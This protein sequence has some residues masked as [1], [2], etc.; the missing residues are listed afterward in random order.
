VLAELGCVEAHVDGEAAIEHLRAARDAIED[1]VPRAQIALL[2]GR[3]LFF[4]RDEEADAV[5]TAALEELAGGVAELLDAGRRF[6][7]VGSRNPA[8]I[9]WQSPA[10]LALLVLGEHDKARRLAGEELELAREWGAPR[11]LGAA[12]RVAGLV[13]GGKRGLARL[14]EAVE[15]L[16]D[17]PAKLEHAKARTEL[18]AALRRAGQRA[19]AREHLRR[20]VELATICGAAALPA[21]GETELLATGARPRRVALSGVESLTPSERRVAEMAAQGPSNREIAQAL[22]VTQRTVEV[23]LTGL[24]RNRVYAAQPPISWCSPVAVP[25]TGWRSMAGE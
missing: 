5:Y 24:Y 25:R 3:Q 13:E 10:A 7:S 6:D 8:P 11:T 23:H 2:L 16:S 12:F 14:G 20:A 17:S 18:G 9:A 1:P 22:F 19:R 15:V 4:L 21:R